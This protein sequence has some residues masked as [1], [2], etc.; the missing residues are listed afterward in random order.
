MN[1][2]ARARILTHGGRKPYDVEVPK[3]LEAVAVV[4]PPSSTG[5]PISQCI[6]AAK[7]AGSTAT[8][9]KAFAADV[10]A[11][12]QAHQDQWVPPSWD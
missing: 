8:L 12:I 1:V 10:E 4:R 6:A 2:R 3:S 5:R 11:G 9:D 7:A